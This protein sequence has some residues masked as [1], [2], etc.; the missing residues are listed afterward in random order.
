MGSPFTKELD[1][2]CYLAIET[3]KLKILAGSFVA[4][5]GMDPYGTNLVKLLKMDGN[6]NVADPVSTGFSTNE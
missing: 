2:F 1:N 3:N 5:E 4:Q 6:I